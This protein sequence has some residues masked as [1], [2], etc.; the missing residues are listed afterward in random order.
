MRKHAGKCGHYVSVLTS[1][2]LKS[3]KIAVAIDCTSDM[4]THRL[5]IDA[6]SELA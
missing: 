1:P 2:T 4:F 6:K 5:Q 3:L